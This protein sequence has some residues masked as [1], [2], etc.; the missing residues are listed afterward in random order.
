MKHC[1]ITLKPYEKDTYITRLDVTM[2]FDALDCMAGKELCRV[3]LVGYSVPGCRPDPFEMID[4]LGV[5]PY[6][7]VESDEYPYK[8]NVYYVERAITGSVCVQYTI[9][10]REYQ[11]DHRCGPYFDFK[12]D[13]AVFYVFN[14]IND[15]FFR[16]EIVAAADLSKPGYARLDLKTLA[17]A[18]NVLLERL[19]KHFSLGAGSNQGHLPRYAGP[20]LRK[21][22]QAGFSDK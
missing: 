16:A 17:E 11:P 18:V 4:A 5:V 20:K 13:R 2:K 10:P 3:M 6:R 9:Y 14:I 15:F 1:K 8:Y 12:T 7:T 22:V 21:L 19:V